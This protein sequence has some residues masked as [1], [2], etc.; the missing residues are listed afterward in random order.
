MHFIK[1]YLLDFQTLHKPK[2]QATIKK[3]PPT[4]V[5]A[6]ISLISIP[7]IVLVDN[8]KIDPE[9]RKTPEITNKKTFFLLASIYKNYLKNYIIKNYPFAQ[10]LKIKKAFYL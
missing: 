7:E 8:K 1:Y 6:P 5:I 10:S 2:L 3:A 9:K 4:G